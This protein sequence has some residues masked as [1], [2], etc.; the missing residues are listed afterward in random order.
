M[1]VGVHGNGGIQ[2]LVRLI[3]MQKTAEYMLTA[4]GIDAPTAAKIDWVNRMH[5][6]ETKLTNHTL[7]KPY[8]SP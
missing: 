2:Y 1:P 4:S 8:S 3:G 6:S 5:T 7:T